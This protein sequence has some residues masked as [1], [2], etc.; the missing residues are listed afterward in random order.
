MGTRTG[1]SG[2]G[3]QYLLLIG[4]TIT[5][6]CC[7]LTPVVAECRCACPTISARGVG[8]TSCSAA[9]DG[10]RLCTVDFNLFGPEREGRA[11]AL[12][13]KSGVA[14][15]KRPE[16]EASA[17]GAIQASASRGS[18]NDTL[19]LFL[20]VALADEPTDLMRNVV[21]PIA[22]AVRNNTEL[23][24]ALRM[25][26]GPGAAA[27]FVK[28]PDSQLSSSFSVERISLPD[29]GQAVVSP[30]CL[31]ITTNQRVWVMFKTEWAASRLQPRCE[32]LQR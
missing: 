7:L 1:A 31:E 20:T 11:A 25:A 10:S 21:A 19:L 2:L 13:A 12:L 27:D 29:L 9:E 28:T 6:I 23:D 15:L 5:A 14:D 4:T 8:N 16:P 30:G 22:G 3:L 26:F 18:L 32:A 24:R 17:T